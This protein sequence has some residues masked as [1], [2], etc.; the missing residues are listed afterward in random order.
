MAE[1]Q[2]NLP[3]RGRGGTCDAE[4][5]PPR[6]FFFWTLSPFLVLFIVVMGLL[7][8]KSEPTKLVLLLT[9]E[10]LAILTLLGLFNARRFW[11]AWRGV[12]AII[13]LGYVA[14]LIAMVIESNGMVKMP[15]RRSEASLV[16]A[17]IGLCIIGLPGLWYALYGRFTFF[18]E[19]ETAEEFVDDDF[20]LEDE[21]AD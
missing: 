15:A 10:L 8:D 1:L 7:I 6:G 12:G 11:W 5:D 9:I 4:Y 18:E 2:S 21:E 14:Y 19:S 17:V 16:N 20:D 3:D 13:F